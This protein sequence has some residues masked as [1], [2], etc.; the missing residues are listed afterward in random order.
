MRYLLAVVAV[1]LMLGSAACATNVLTNGGF[2]TNPPAAPDDPIPGW[3]MVYQSWQDVTDFHWEIQN[4]DKF[5]GTHALRLYLGPLSWGAGWGVK[6]TVPVTRFRIYEASARWKYIN[7]N[8]AAVNVLTFYLFPGTFGTDSTTP[9]IEPRPMQATEVYGIRST[10]SALNHPA[11]VPMPEDWE[12]TMDAPFTPYEPNGVVGTSKYRSRIYSTSSSMTIYIRATVTN[13][14]PTVEAFVD[15]VRLEQVDAAKSVSGIVRNATTSAPIAGA[16]VTLA[17]GGTATT[18]ANGAYRIEFPNAGP[19]TLSASAVHYNDNS[20]AVNLTSLGDDVVNINLTPLP[21]GTLSGTVTDGTNPI[22]GATVSIVGE[23]Y[24]TQTNE[25]GQYS[26]EVATGS[27]TAKAVQIG[28]EPLTAPVSIAVGQTTTANFTLAL[29]YVNP[30]NALTNGDFESGMAPWT[31]WCATHFTAHKGADPTCPGY[32]DQWVA[33]AGA[34]RVYPTVAAGEGYGGSAAAK[35][36]VG[37]GSLAWAAV[38]GLRQECYVVPGK[39]YRARAM[40][41]GVIAPAASDYK[42]SIG[43]IN[44]RF[45]PG[46]YGTPVPEHLDDL[47]MYA[48]GQE[49]SMLMYSTLPEGQRWWDNELALRSKAY[50]GMSSWDWASTMD[51]LSPR[52][53]FIGATKQ[54]TGEKMTVVL[55]ADTRIASGEPSYALFDNVVLEEVPAPTALVKLGDLGNVD[56][57]PPYGLY[58]ELTASI[59]VDLSDPANAK[60]VTAVFQGVFGDTYYY[61]EELDRTAG[62]RIQPDTNDYFVPQVGDMVTLKGKLGVALTG[63]RVIYA[64]SGSQS[65]ISSGAELPKPL[66]ITLKS[67]SAKFQYVNPLG[68]AYGPANTG[69]LVT[70]TGKVVSSYSDGFDIYV[71]IDDGSGVEFWLKGASE[72]PTPGAQVVATGVLGIDNV[73]AGYPVMLL[74]IRPETVNSDFRI[75]P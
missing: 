20:V 60:V 6:Q 10:Q 75:L 69:L 58:P 53:P 44:G 19:G 1:L 67:A 74:Q 51:Y 17:S 41:K 65:S 4:T 27:F 73:I 66:G 11:F 8:P 31:E 56:L 48:C 15:D 71:M 18:D 45:D 30:V 43:L 32:V 26:M 24:S 33:D 49:N 23:V 7:F 57:S 34:A 68:Q 5:S 35:M 72:E 59:P 47:F 52:N 29:R 42:V 55:F 62:I 14:S 22:K 2:D 36:G 50:Y 54:A 39:Y 61:I 40:F 16:T 25:F 63:E 12:S 21:T 28:Y 64:D 37:L 3:T 46:V 38:G 9:I 13:Q 70:V